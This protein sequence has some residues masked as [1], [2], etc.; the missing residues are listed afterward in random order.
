MARRPLPP[1]AAVI[2][3]IDCINRGDLD[4]LA[5]SMTGDHTLIVLDEPPLVGRSRNRE[6]WD[7]YMAAYSN[8][9]IYPRY[10]ATSGTSVAV[11]GTTT[12]SHLGMTEEEEMQLDAIW[13]AEVVDGRLSS[14]H[15]ADDTPELRAEV[16]IPLTA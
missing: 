11:L 5:E 7:G 4:D 2:G 8:Y 10:I 6:A 15:I 1:A 14:W 16:G 13:L 12:G 9:V 3:F